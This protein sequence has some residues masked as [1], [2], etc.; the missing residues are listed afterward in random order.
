MMSPTLIWLTRNCFSTINPQDLAVF[1]EVGIFFTTPNAVDIVKDSAHYMTKKLGGSGAVR[2]ICDLII[3]SRG[4]N[5]SLEFERY[6][7]KE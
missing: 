2:E 6:I 1:N 3:C 4:S 5:S 7:K